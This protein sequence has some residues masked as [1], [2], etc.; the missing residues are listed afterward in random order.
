MAQSLSADLTHLIFS[1]KNREPFI[2]AAIE[3]E[4]LPGPLAQAFTFRAFGA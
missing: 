4:P 3:K 2:T 1:T